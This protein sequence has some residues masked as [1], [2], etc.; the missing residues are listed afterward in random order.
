MTFCWDTENA[1]FSI[2]TVDGMSASSAVRSLWGVDTDWRVGVWS[3]T[4]WIASVGS[5]I[6]TVW[7]CGAGRVSGVF[8]SSIS[9]SVE[10]RGRFLVVFLVNGA[11]VRC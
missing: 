10:G 4:G 8:T 1:M 2:C 11:I 3:F 7:A 6:S 9:T 5:W